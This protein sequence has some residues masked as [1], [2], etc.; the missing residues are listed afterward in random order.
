M[1]VYRFFCRSQVR[2][3]LKF[4]TWQLYKGHSK[5]YTEQVVEPIMAWQTRRHYEKAWKWAQNEHG[6]ATATRCQLGIMIVILVKNVVV[7]NEVSPRPRSLRLDTVSGSHPDQ[8]CLKTE[9]LQWRRTHYLR[10]QRICLK[11]RLPFAASSRFKSL[12]NETSILAR[13]KFKQKFKLLCA[14]ECVLHYT[15]KFS[16]IKLEIN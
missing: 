3:W 10:G 2:D 7:S 4:K 6:I 1:I 12:T 11:K 14:V 13:Y 15:F 9:E 5:C 16:L 8:G